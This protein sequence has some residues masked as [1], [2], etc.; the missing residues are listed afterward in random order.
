MPAKVKGDPH[1]SLDSVG[2]VR[3]GCGVSSWY[4]TVCKATVT[5]FQVTERVSCEIMQVTSSAWGSTDS[6]QQLMGKEVRI[7]QS[8]CGQL[9]LHIG[10]EVTF[11]CILI[12][13]NPQLGQKKLVGVLMGGSRHLSQCPCSGFSWQVQLACYS[14]AHCT[15]AS[16]N[17][18]HFSTPTPETQ[19]KIWI[20]PDHDGR[21]VRYFILSS[22]RV[23]GRC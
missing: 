3:V 23:W 6:L 19:T 12:G 13:D 17:R 4:N 22:A 5:V 1:G 14:C 7:R 10:D 21:C 15:H 11:Y 9:R 18:I 8:D 20:L 16:W 2:R